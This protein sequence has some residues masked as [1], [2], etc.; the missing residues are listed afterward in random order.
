[1][2]DFIDSKIEGDELFIYFTGHGQMTQVPATK[3]KKKNKKKWVT[4]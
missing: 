4:I 3:D 1:M 2:M